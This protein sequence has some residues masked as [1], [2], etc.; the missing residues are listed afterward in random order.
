MLNLRAVGYERDEAGKSKPVV[1]DSLR[2]VTFD[3]ELGLPESLPYCCLTLLSDGVKGIYWRRLAEK[4]ELAFEPSCHRELTHWHCR[5]GVCKNPKHE[6]LVLFV[7]ALEAVS[8]GTVS[9]VFLH[10][11]SRLHQ[12]LARAL[13]IPGQQFSADGQA[14][15]W[16]QRPGTVTLCPATCLHLRQSGFL[17][18]FRDPLLALGI[19]EIRQLIEQLKDSETDDRTA[20][21][22]RAASASGFF[23]G[24]K[25]PGAHALRLA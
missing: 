23:S 4:Y 13:E 17:L 5:D 12:W 21:P 7:V 10:E 6:A 18:P 1:D 22:I 16:E 2:S 11:V 14:A 3:D 19:S 15:D 25:S 9:A 20:Q 24:T 8:C